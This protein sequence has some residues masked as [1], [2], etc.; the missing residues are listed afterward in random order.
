MEL[1][2]LVICLLLWSR[3]LSAFLDKTVVQNKSKLHLGCQRVDVFFN[4][5]DLKCIMWQAKV[6]I[7]YIVWVN[8]ISYSLMPKCI[9][10][11][12]VKIMLHE[13]IL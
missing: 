1:A 10:I 8:I 5:V 3:M 4:G 12:K 9:E 11:F 6:Y 2:C 7:Q 13:D